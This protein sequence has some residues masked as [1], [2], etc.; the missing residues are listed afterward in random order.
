MDGFKNSTR[1]HYMKGG[2]C[3][4]YAKGGSVKGAAKI[5]K[6]MGEFKSGALHSGSKSGPEVT[7][8]KQAVAIALSEA[9][10]AGAK[11]PAKKAAGGMVESTSARPVKV[12]MTPE[13]RATNAT[14]RRAERVQAEEANESRIARE[15]RK[16][17][18]RSREVTV[19]RRMDTERSVRTPLGDR[20]NRLPTKAEMDMARRGPAGAGFS[21]RPLVD[22]VRG[23]LGLK[24]GGLAS[25]PRG[26]KC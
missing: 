6:V 19:E 18:P 2:S 20:L 17:T 4:G 26:K 3:E 25:M 15:T 11:V 14:L 22:R 9:R 21:V 1:T 12:G 10:K 16:A 23:A 8:P 7:N 5:A 24:N 13:E